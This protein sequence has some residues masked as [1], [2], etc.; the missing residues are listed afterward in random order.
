[1]IDLCHQSL[2]SLH[3]FVIDEC[4][5]EYESAAALLQDEGRVQQQ[6]DT[7]TGNGSLETQDLFVH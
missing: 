7:N 4:F 2:Q 6:S 1:M 3:D 5:D